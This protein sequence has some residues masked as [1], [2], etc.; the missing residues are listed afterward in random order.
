MYT[1]IDFETTGLSP[2]DSE[3]IEFA[4]VRVAPDT[5][6]ALALGESFT[7]LCS[8][9]MT[10]ITPTITRIT[11]ITD[12]MTAGFPPF[13]ERLRE[14]CAFIGNDTIAAHNI[15]FDMGFLRRYC[16]G[17]GFAPP[18]KTLCTLVKSRQLCRSLYNHKLETVAAHLG[19]NGEGYHRALADAVTTAK[20]L[21]KL[22]SL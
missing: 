2:S 11:G 22:L 15:P 4:A 14:F 5:S 3:V 13:E 1:V 10:L 12:A 8:P 19:V 21:I 16:R 20:V 7:S 17:A 9:R 18:E 6:G